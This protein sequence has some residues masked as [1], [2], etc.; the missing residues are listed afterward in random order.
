MDPSA[1]RQLDQMVEQIV[2]TVP[3]RAIY[4]FGSHARGDARKGSDID[5]YVLTD[6]DKKHPMD[7]IFE[8]NSAIRP[9]EK[10]PTDILALSY[11]RFEE[12]SILFPTLEYTVAKEDKRIYG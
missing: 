1:Q 2:A 8:I 4:L 6:D 5:I 12:R 7:C 11:R 9:I 10:I 3:T